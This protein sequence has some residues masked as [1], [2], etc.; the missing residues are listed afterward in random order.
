MPSLPSRISD[1]VA[2]KRLQPDLARGLRCTVGFMVPVVV[3][4]LWHLPIEAAFAA[5]AAQNTTIVDIRGSYPLRLSI[6]LAMSVIMAGAAWLGGVSAPSV[7]FS[8]CAV[9]LVT[10]A[11]GVWRHLSVDYGPSLAVGSIFLFLFSISLPGGEAAAN[12]HFTSTLLGGFWGALVQVSLWPIRAQHPLRRAVGDTWLA[13]SDLISAMEPSPEGNGADSRHQRVGQTETTFRTAINQALATLNSR[14]ARTPTVL[15]LEDLNLAAARLATRCFAFNTAFEALMQRPDFAV[16]APSF[17]PA[18][19][20]M[21]NLA[22][23]IAYTVVSR[24]P[25]HLASAEVRMKRL[26]NLLKALQDRVIAQTAG[27]ADGLQVAGFLQQITTQL[28]AATSALRATVE[29]ADER[30]AFSLELLDVQTWT[31]R[32]LASALNFRWPPTPVLVRYILRLTV[33]VLIGAAVMKFFNLSRGYWL[34][35]TILVVLQP[36]YGSTRLRAAQRVIGTLS[37]GV[38]A[39]LLLWLHLPATLHLLALAGSMFGFAATVRRNYGV[40]VV[41]ITLLVVLLT[42][43]AA[44]VTVSF[45]LERMIATVAGGVLALIGAQL[46][47]PLWERKYLRPVLSRALRANR[48]YLEQVLLALAAGGSYAGAVLDAKRACDAANSVVFSSLQRM[49]G[50]PRNQQNGME[51]VAALANG[52]QRFTRSL[53]VVALN[54]GPALRL[55]HPKLDAFSRLSAEVLESLAGAVETFQHDPSAFVH[56][57]DALNRISLPYEELRPGV[58]AHTTTAI[59]NQFS[60]A[61]TELSAMILATSALLEANRVETGMGKAE[62]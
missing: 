19:T 35:L 24:Q 51:S 31:L 1:F 37:G 61:A 5:T 32:P 49:F 39:S 3:A 10:L 54:L 7:A 57:E 40:S 46:F 62:G 38:A 45:T 47:W 44:H 9:V 22:R 58:D 21:T 26:G 28:A 36:D 2:R 41:F 60:R 42:E 56:A 20:S 8:L 52:N 50:D 25:S 30:A 59:F 14:N 33:L 11:A 34:P 16:L 29:R 23:G 27:A 12:H 17:G 53:N 18:F 13:L 15:K 4:M 43:T 55:T 6:L 48:T